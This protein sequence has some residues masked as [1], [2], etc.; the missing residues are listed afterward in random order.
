MDRSELLAEL[1]RRIDSVKRDH[2]LRVAIDGV[3]AAGKTTLA[4]ELAGRL[5]ISGR[6]VIR[7]SI[8]GF[9]NPRAVRYRRGS[10][11]PEGYFLDSFD[12]NALKRLLLV[13][14]GPV[15]N[16]EY[17]TTIFDYRTE[18]ALP[19]PLRRARPDSILVFDG[20]FLLR[21]E[22]SGLW[23][24]RLFVHADFDTVIRRAVLRDRGLFGTAE[25]VEERY[26]KRYIPGQ[27]MYL[28][29]CKPQTHANA[30]VDNNNPDR[31]EL[32][33]LSEPA[34]RS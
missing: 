20:I 11:S 34:D 23:D 7:A 1:T 24:Y 5:H 14:L 33:I 13:P 30:V 3:D 18:S 32:R 16:R 26:R 31:P 12:Y 22:L 28:D 25:Q 15:G 17:Q 10:D 29:L 27:Q 8:D 6:Q 4:Y 9:H 21:E 19:S 2:P